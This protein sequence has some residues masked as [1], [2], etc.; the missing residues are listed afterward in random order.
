MADFTEEEL[1]GLSETE[2]AALEDESGDEADIKDLEALLALGD[3][4]DDLPPDGD[5]KDK[6][7]LPLVEAAPAPAPTLPDPSAFDADILTAKDELKKLKESY[8]SVDSEM[9]LDEYEDQREALV[10]KLAAVR[11]QKA[12]A[13]AIVEAHQATVEAQQVAN[14]KLWNNQ[15]NQFLATT[16]TKEGIDYQGDDI[17]F[18]ALDAQ[19][20]SLA[21]ANPDKDGPWI[22]EQAHAAIKK[23]FRLGPT[24]GA[25]KTDAVQDELAKRRAASGK[26]APTLAHLPEAGSEDEPGGNGEFGYLDKLK[27]LDLEVALRKLSPEQAARYLA[28]N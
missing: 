14:Q 11:E 24:S 25:K 15:V 28:A 26:P 23:S 3:E 17:L 2:R 6:D 18:N 21:K 22:L 16:K 20:I 1:S 13:E 5:G 4:G 7:D 10:E 9:S 27:G 12:R 8:A 19:V